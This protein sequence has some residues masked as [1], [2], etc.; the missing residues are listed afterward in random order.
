MFD[1]APALNRMVAIVEGLPGVQNVY[2]G[3]PSRVTGAG[4][5]YV[6]YGR[7][8]VLNKTNDVLQR[9][10]RFIL[11]FCYAV[12]GVAVEGAERAIGEAVDA[13]I[14][15]IWLEVEDGASPLKDLIEVDL[16]LSDTAEYQV[17]VGQEFRRYPVAVSYIQQTQIGV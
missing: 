4:A 6:T 15:A 2:V 1:A 11:T 3:V 10:L 9:E 14:D 5:C 12:D 16:S 13:L 17:N 7:Q 8:R